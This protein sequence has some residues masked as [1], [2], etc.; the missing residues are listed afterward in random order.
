MGKKQT[1]DPFVMHHRS[2]LESVARREMDLAEY[3]SLDVIE[4]ELMRHGGK[5]GPSGGVPVPFER[6]IEHGVHKNSI[7]P[8]IRGLVA[9]G[10]IRVTKKGRG[11]N[12]AHRE[13]GEYCI[14]YA[15]AKIG[16]AA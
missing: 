8:A 6:F 5:Y 11:G 3:Q 16:R 15:R 7:A 14:T 12:A 10:K 13:V 4:I 2:L 1:D 9:L